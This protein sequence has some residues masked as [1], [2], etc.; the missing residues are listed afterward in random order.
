[1]LLRVRDS[2]GDSE[3]AQTMDV[4]K[5]GALFLGKHRHRVG[6]ILF[7]TLPSID[8]PLPIEQ[9]ARIVRVQ[10]AM[11]GT[12]YAVKFEKA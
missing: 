8:K 2:Q 11:R 9:R 4:S 6:D 5:G 7:L 12:L 1:M 3:V 10:Q